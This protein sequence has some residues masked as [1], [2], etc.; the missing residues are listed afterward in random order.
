MPLY[1]YECPDC[2]GFE[3]L[4]SIASRDAPTFCP[5]CGTRASRVQTI[6][7]LS[8]MD[9]NTRSAHATNER[10]RHEPKRSSTHVHGPGCGCGSGISKSTAK[11]P[12]G[13]KSFPGKRPW[14]ISH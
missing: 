8:L 3:T 14:M 2:G 5:R 12:D 9:G 10:A 4:R 11:A 6:S 13:S 1:D 7:A